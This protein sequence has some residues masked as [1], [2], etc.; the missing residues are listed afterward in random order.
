MGSR[1]LRALAVCA[2]VAVLAVVL[3]AA[4]SLPT[5]S[6]YVENFN[7]IGTST[8]AALPA[9]FRADALIGARVVGTF[10]AAGL[11]TTRAASANMSSTAANGI[12]N[13]DA[14]T[15]TTALGTERAVGFLSSGTATQSGN[16]YAELANNTET[17]LSGL[18]I[19]Y[20]VEKYRGGSNAAGFR[21]QLYYSADGGAWTSA[22]SDF[23][24]AFPADAANAGFASAPGV[25][26][27]VNKTLSAA[28]PVGGTLYLAWNYSVASGTTTSNAQ[29]LAIDDINITG[30]VDDT[31]PPDI[32]PA[33][34]SSTPANG[35][36]N[37]SVG[38]TISVTFSESV[39]AAAGAF[40]VVCAGVPQPFGVSASPANNFTLTPGRFPTRRL[41]PSR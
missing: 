9:N 23:T 30:I 36:S 11:T 28:I 10:A 5:G 7:G 27:N 16:L 20:N 25:T 37:V 24:T 3:S 22:G 40:S 19:A 8:M 15:T 33:V 29:A 6:P 39:N 21:I 13:F 26:V 34:T 14:G 31:P 2:F 1:S 35:A 18:Q 12:Y 38:S 32:A 41:A 17:A 4:I